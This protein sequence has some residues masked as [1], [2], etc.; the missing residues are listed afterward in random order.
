MSEIALKK[1]IKTFLFF[2]APCHFL[3]TLVRRRLL[4]L[5]VN[6]KPSTSAISLMRTAQK[7]GE[8]TFLV[9]PFHPTFLSYEN[10]TIVN[11]HDPKERIVEQFFDIAWMLPFGFL[12]R[13]HG[14]TT[15]TMTQQAAA[16]NVAKQNHKFQYRLIPLGYA[17]ISLFLLKFFY[18]LCGRCDTPSR[19]LV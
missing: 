8:K 2:H 12:E 11:H 19:H 14:Y 3:K 7:K 13:E 4:L 18:Y 1:Y 16:L 10:E 5:T 6:R 15:T 9:L 17:W